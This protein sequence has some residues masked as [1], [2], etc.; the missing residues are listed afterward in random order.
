MEIVTDS[1]V[2]NVLEFMQANIRAER[3]LWVSGAV[4]TLA[5]ALWGEKPAC[6][7]KPGLLHEQQLAAT[8][9]L[10]ASECADDGSVV[11]MGNR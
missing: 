3:L 5:T 11:A 10:P 8:Q 2:K 4:A 9:L 1:D 6:S 7:L